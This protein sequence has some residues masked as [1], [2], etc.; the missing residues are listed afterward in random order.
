MTLPPNSNELREIAM[1]V[2]DFYDKH[3][4]GRTLDMLGTHIFAIYERRFEEDTTKEPI[5]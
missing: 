1:L 3:G 2:I 5:Q 4:F